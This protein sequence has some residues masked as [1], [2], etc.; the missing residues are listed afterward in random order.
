MSA[1]EGGREGGRG[2]REG[3]VR[4]EVRGERGERREGGDS[5]FPMTVSIKPME[6]LKRMKFLMWS[7]SSMKVDCTVWRSL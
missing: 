6:N 1:R 5:H 3:V 2:G 7:T 4:E